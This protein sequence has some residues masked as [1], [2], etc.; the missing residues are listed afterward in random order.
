MRS[1]ILF[2]VFNR[3]IPTDKVFSRIRLAKPPKL[4]IACDGPKKENPEEDNKVRETRNLLL[5]SF[6]E[7]KKKKY[8]LSK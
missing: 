5:K 2:L 1:P 3:P 4:Y 6:K 7:V 8:L